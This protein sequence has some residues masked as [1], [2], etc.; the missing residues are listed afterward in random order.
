M[1]CLLHAR[2]N[3]AD[4]YATGRFAIDVTDA[5]MD[6]LAGLTVMT[7]HRIVNGLDSTHTDAD[8]IGR[9]LEALGVS[10]A[11]ARQLATDALAGEGDS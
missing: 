6:Q 7:I 10:A 3:V 5:V 8:A 9:G 11:E 4:G 1:I 2:Q